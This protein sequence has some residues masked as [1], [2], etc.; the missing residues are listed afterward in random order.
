MRLVLTALAAM[1]GTGI[2][3]AF[4]GL[5]ALDGPVRSGVGIP[6]LSPSPPP[7]TATPICFPTFPPYPTAMPYPTAAPYPTV[8]RE[9]FEVVIVTPPPT[10]YVIT[11]TPRPT[12][13]WEPAPTTQPMPRVP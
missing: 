5:S 8:P 4:Y 2:G 6:T 12:P 7:S 1:L 11:P 9:P 3:L 10:P 13:T